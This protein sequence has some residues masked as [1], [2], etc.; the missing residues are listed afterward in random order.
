M[1]HGCFDDDADLQFPPKLKQAYVSVTQGYLGIERQLKEPGLNEFSP[2]DLAGWPPTISTALATNG[3]YVEAECESTDEACGIGCGGNVGN[4]AQACALAAI[5]DFVVMQRHEGLHQRA[6]QWSEAD[7]DKES[8]GLGFI[9]THAEE[10][11][12]AYVNDKDVEELDRAHAEEQV[13]DPEFNDKR[14]DMNLPADA[15]EPHSQPV[16]RAPRAD[17]DDGPEPHSQPVSQAPRAAW[18]SGAASWWSEL[19]E[20]TWTCQTWTS[21]TMMSGAASW[22]SAWSERL[23]EQRRVPEPGW[24]QAEAW[25]EWP[26]KKAEAWSESEWPEPGAAS[27]SVLDQAEAPQKKAEAWSEWPQKKAEAA[28]AWSESEWPEPGAA[29]RSVLDQAEAPQEQRRAPFLP[30]NFGDVPMPGPKQHERSPSSQRIPRQPSVPPPGWGAPKKAEAAEASASPTGR[31]RRRRASPGEQRLRGPA[32][33]CAPHLEQRLL[34]PVPTR[35][36]CFEV[37]GASPAD[38][39]HCH[40]FEV[41]SGPR[42]LESSSLPPPPPPPP[43]P[44]PPKPPPKP[45]ARS[46]SPI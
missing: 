21:L 28:E 4:R 34:S 24:P 17:N 10:L 1:R 23:E 40:S 26:Q 20:E 31:K 27:R 8:P 32:P 30:E 41:R 12:C 7:L 25:S 44:Q 5:I 13:E 9:V 43:P 36:P 42:R 6:H 33:T 11:Y 37:R 15:L 46:L 45:E 3:L 19:P 35:A 2:E 14:G 39:H 29:S 22:W 16:S 18:R 38:P